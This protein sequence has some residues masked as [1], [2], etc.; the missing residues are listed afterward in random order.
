MS[1]DRFTRR[2][3]YNPCFWTA[4]WNVSYFNSVNSGGRPS[5]AARDQL[6]SVLNVRS[7]KI[8]PTTVNRVHFDGDLGTAEITP[9]S[10]KDFCQ[11]WRPDKYE[12]ISA[13]VDDH[14]QS[15]YLDFEDIL[16]AIERIPGYKYLIE[17]AQPNGLVSDE[18]KGFLAGILIIHAMRSHEMMQAMLEMT[19]S[20]GIAKWEYFWLLKNWW[21]NPFFLA[22]AVTPL[23]LGR[24]V[25]YKSHVHKFPLCDSPVMIGRHSL[26]A[27]LSPRLLLEVNLNEIRHP[28]GCQVRQGIS[29]S[30]FREFRRR[31][32]GNTFKEILFNDADELMA[33]RREQE[34]QCR[35]TILADIEK[36]RTALHNAAARVVWALQGFGRVPDDFEGK[37][38][39]HFFANIPT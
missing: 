39:P 12:E 2:N 5:V 21:S 36:R 30:K 26:L 8:Y 7:G 13:Y 37:V 10:M 15:L 31:A 33:W 18:Q 6:V 1:G 29:P 17:A 24:W 20:I 3:H 23:A 28:A 38:A 22:R 27:I 35:M 19:A 25:L 16:E 9:E 4:L 32:I 11:R 34:F 14:P